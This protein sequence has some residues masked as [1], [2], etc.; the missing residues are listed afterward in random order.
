MS[1][2]RCSTG[3]YPSLTLMEVLNDHIQPLGIPA[4]YAAMIGHIQDKF[5]MSIGVNEI[6]DFPKIKQDAITFQ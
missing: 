6:C 2:T 4:W 1:C 5:T 3:D